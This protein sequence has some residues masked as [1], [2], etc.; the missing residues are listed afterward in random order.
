M[1]SKRAVQGILS[2]RG[3]SSRGFATRGFF[4][5]SVSIVLMGSIEPIKVLNE[6]STQALVSKV[7]FL[8]IYECKM[9]NLGVIYQ[10]QQN[11]RVLWD[12]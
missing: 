8:V 4:R 3:F 10:F 9:V 6:V 5:G 7:K 2:S 1:A 11:Q 12:L